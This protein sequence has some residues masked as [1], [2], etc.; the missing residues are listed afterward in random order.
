MAAE[1]PTA[2]CAFATKSMVTLLVIDP[3]M[4]LLARTLLAAST[5]PL[6]NWFISIMRIPFKDPLRLR[7]VA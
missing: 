1:P 2:S 6:C 7:S 5:I 4:G 3:A